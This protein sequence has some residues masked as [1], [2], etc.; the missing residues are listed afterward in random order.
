M[1][2][3]LA[4]GHWRI[5][6]LSCGTLLLLLAWNTVV[7][8]GLTSLAAMLF[9]LKARLISPLI[10]S[11]IKGIQ[12][13][14]PLSLPVFCFFLLRLLLLFGV[15]AF[16]IKLLEYPFCLNFSVMIVLASFWNSGVLFS[17]A[18]RNSFLMTA[19]FVDVGW[20]DSEWRMMPLLATLVYNFRW[21]VPSCSILNL[22]S[23]I[24]KKPSSSGNSN[25]NLIM[26]YWLFR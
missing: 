10:L 7:G 13:T 23:R 3:L 15:V 24:G 16:L 26:A 11:L 20:C 9:C 6:H 19:P 12:R 1:L 21:I 17:L 18:L 5:V 14:S 4:R 22:M 2:L 25:S 8:R